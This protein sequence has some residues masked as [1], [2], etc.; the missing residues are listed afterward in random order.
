[1]AWLWD[2]AVVAGGK[3]PPRAPADLLRPQHGQRREGSFGG[4]SV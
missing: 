4:D 1:M 2:V 3:R